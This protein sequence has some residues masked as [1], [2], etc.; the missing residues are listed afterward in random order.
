MLLKP[1]WNLLNKMWQMTKGT[2]FIIWSNKKLSALRL[3]G[4]GGVHANVKN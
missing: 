3:G 1:N 2:G 4:D